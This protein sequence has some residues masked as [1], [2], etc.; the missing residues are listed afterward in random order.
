MRLTV[1]VAVTHLLG[2]GHLARAAAIGRALAGRGHRV[3]LIS[4]GLP[5]PLVATDGLDV[6]Q[7]PPVRTRGTAFTTLLDAQDRPVDAATMAARRERIARTV[8]DLAPDVLVTELFPF[9]R[10]VLADEFLAAVAAARRARPEVAV[11]ASVRDILA[12]PG[13]PGRV[14]ETHARVAELYDG[15]LVHADPALVPLE[16]SWP[17]DAALRER[18]RYTGYVADGRT[19]GTGPRGDEIL[20]SGGGSAASLPLYRAAVAAARRVARPWRILVGAGVGE[21]DLADLVA[22]A[23]A[24]ARVERARPDFPDLLGRAALSVSQ[25]GYNTVVDLLRAGTPAVLVPFADGHETEQALRARA[26]AARGRAR[27]IDAG[28]LTAEALAEAVEASLAAPPPPA[29]PLAL[30]GAA[31]SARSVEAYAEARRAPA[32]RRPG[33]DWRPLDAA[34]RRREEDGAPVAAWWRDD[35]AVTASPALDRLLTLARAAGWP[36][37]LAVVPGRIEPS[38]P[39]RIAG[40][41]GLDVLVHGLVH[42]D[43]APPGEKKAEFGP[44]RPLPEMEEDVVRAL[45]LAQDAFPGKALP[46]FVP[47]WNRIAPD[48]AARLPALGY[49][50]L[51]TFRADRRRLPSLAPLETHLD[52]ID[53]HGTRGLADRDGLVRDLAAA[54]DGAA[55]V[56]LL[57]H[58]AIHDE[59]VWAFLAALLDRLAASPAVRPRRASQALPAEAPRLAEAV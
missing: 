19:A 3:T 32:V 48:L 37:G 23:P 22:A 6:V 13:K 30:D 16:A 4:G 51:S 27:V 47:P 10:R 38:L 11:L 39:E 44:H 45:R 40:E 7:L 56:G 43:H 55:P 49:R 14:A 54:I 28:A 29:L 15:V 2:I 58:H 20:V 57:T 1:A 46:V 52:P 9:G 12:A 50:A 42:R 36:V 59:A 26:L 24:N 18:L 8:A 35:D 33:P 53:W 5:A 34:L 25:A 41:P 21:A 17:V 31:E